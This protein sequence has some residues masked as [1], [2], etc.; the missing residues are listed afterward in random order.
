[1]NTYIALLR[2]INVGGHN[3]LPMKELRSM[4]EDLGHQK[5]D[6]YIQTGNAVFQTEEN[7]ILQISSDISA[8]IKKRY[9]FEPQILILTLEDFKRAVESNPFP[10]KES[11]PKLLHLYF[12]IS[13]PSNPDLDEL[14]NIKKESERFE[15][16]DKVFYLHAPDGIGRS[17]LAGMLAGRS[18]KVF[19]CPVTGR[20]W[21]TVQKIMEMVEEC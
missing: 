20:N 21:R 16:K 7:N 19:G 17:K 3:R 18:E 4:M 9:G 11:D 10:E 2:G 5:V 1:M 15:L 8:E 12:L 13:E 6:T 14:N